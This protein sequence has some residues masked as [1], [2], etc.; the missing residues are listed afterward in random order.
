MLLQEHLVVLRSGELKA[1]SG[2]QGCGEMEGAGL[3]MLLRGDNSFSSE[4]ITH[5]GSGYPQP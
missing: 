5:T 2:L 1:S 3:W 4:Q